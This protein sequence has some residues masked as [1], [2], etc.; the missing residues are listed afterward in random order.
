MKTI[1]IF[2]STGSIGINTLNVIQG[3]DE[4]F[5]IKYLTANSNSELL[6]EQAIKFQPE[7]V[8]VVNNEKFK[9]VREALKQTD[10]KVIKGR[11]GLLEC[12]SDSE[13]DIMMNGL[14]GTAGMEPTF[15]AVS[16]GVDVALSNKESLVM[17]GDLINRE[18]KI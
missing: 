8:V 2:G 16:S 11:K 17:A 15:R 9:L 3:L 18:K 14:V 7:H 5:I 12:A 4:H 6:I 10:I 13:V 1:S